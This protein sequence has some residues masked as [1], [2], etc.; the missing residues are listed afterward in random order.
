MLPAN[1]TVDIMNSTYPYTLSNG[2]TTFSPMSM[3]KRYLFGRKIVQ[4]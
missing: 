3:V 4:E 2:M 1:V